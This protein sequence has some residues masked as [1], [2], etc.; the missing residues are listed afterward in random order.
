MADLYAQGATRPYG[1]PDVKS[2]ILLVVLV[3]STPAGAQVTENWVTLGMKDATCAEWNREKAASDWA[4][5][6][7]RAWVSGVISGY[8]AARGG[9]IASSTNGAGVGGGSINIVRITR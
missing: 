7:K 3:C 6:N 1:G 8:N 5:A 9:N 2:H 4:Y